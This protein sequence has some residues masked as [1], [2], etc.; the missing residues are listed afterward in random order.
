MA[1]T[2]HR[3]ESAQYFAA[4]RTRDSASCPGKL[5]VS[6][7]ESKTWMY[8]EISCSLTTTWALAN[9]PHLSTSSQLEPPDVLV[10]PQHLPAAILVVPNAP[11]PIAAAVLDRGEAVADVRGLHVGAADA[12][13]ARDVPHGFGRLDVVDGVGVGAR[14]DRTPAC[15]R[16][17]SSS[18]RLPASMPASHVPPNWKMANRGRSPRRTTAHFAPVPRFLPQDPGRTVRHA[19]QVAVVTGSMSANRSSSRIT[20]TLTGVMPATIP[21]PMAPFFS[22]SSRMQ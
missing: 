3:Q 10:I 14:G 21:R 20:F 9:P 16:S 18:R 1:I 2:S 4:P 7:S 11:D 8:S 6:L 22:G 17:S 13:I 15:T 19:P 5:A 12:R